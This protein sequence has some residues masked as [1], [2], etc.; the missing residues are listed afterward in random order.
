MSTAGGF[1]CHWPCSCYGPDSGNPQLPDIMYQQKV[2][3]KLEAC[4]GFA[5]FSPVH[6]YATSTGVKSMFDRLVC[7]NLT[8]S[9]EEA[10]ML[11]GNE[12]KNP[13][14]TRAL[15]QGNDH[16]HML[17]NWL[18]GKVAAFYVHGDDGADDYTG[19]QPRPPSTINDR[20]EARVSAPRRA[21]DPIV[22]QVRYSG[23]YA[24]DSLI[25]A[26][27][28]GKGVDYATSNDLSLSGPEAKAGN[29][30]RRLAREIRARRR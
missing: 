4:D 24:P 2:Y 27:V 1:H 10:R 13:K 20:A 28:I 18:T 3:E 23:I 30:L 22:A 8:V 17:K 9:V 6:W 11:T 26:V 29:L 15:A 19:D 16:D 7:A 5:V 21:I 14:K 12:I 25:E